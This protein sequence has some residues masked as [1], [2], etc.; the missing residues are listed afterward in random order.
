LDKRGCLIHWIGS[1]SQLTK[2]KTVFAILALI[3]VSG[4]IRSA[5]LA[6]RAAASDAQAATGHP[7]GS[8]SLTISVRAT[9]VFV[10]S[11]RA[12][13]V[14]G[15]AATDGLVDIYIYGPNNGNPAD[16]GRSRSQGAGPLVFSER[17]IRV[18]DRRWSS[19]ISHPLDAEQSSYYQINV[20]QTWKEGY[21][22]SEHA[23]DGMDLFRVNNGPPCGPQTSASLIQESLDWAGKERSLLAIDG[24]A[25]N[26]SSV[27]MVVSNTDG[28]VLRTTA[29]V[30][31]GECEAGK[32]MS[33]ADGAYVVQV[34]D[35]EGKLLTKGN[36]FVHPN[37]AT[38]D[39][40]SLNQSLSS[41]SKPCI[42]GSASVQVIACLVSGSYS[43]A[44][45]YDTLSRIVR[46]FRPGLGVGQTVEIEPNLA[47]SSESPRFRIPVRTG[48]PHSYGGIWPGTYRLFLFE[49]TDAHE[50]LKS[51]TFT[52]TR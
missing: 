41:N 15:G 8:S 10:D 50:L 3:S 29:R 21:T 1:G 40:S 33:V 28:E 20:N 2:V 45:D 43:G 7:S 14:G 44:T 37:S 39:L 30:I 22:Y 6:Q 16:I 47:P 19:S 23:Q 31:N 52:L 34:Y 25:C 32:D 12:D 51:S 11:L 18:T 9:G 26:I 42:T 13:S 24:Y 4:F 35:G 46:A 49:G 27:T 48:N 5:A 17:N 38:I 36:F